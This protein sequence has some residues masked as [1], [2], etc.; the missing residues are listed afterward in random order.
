M[1]NNYEKTFFFFNF[2]IT[3]NLFKKIRENN[4]KE[5]LHP[6][7]SVV[8]TREYYQ[9]PIGRVTIDKNI[10]YQ[11]VNNSTTRWYE[12]T[13]KMIKYW[14]IYCMCDKMPLVH[15]HTS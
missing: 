1:K 4:I 15:G 9:S 6:K 11:K 3:F 7:L 5:L 12:F 13:L 2:I 10:S 8:Y 14:F